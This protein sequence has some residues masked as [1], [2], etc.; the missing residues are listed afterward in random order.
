MLT[1]VGAAP[2]DVEGMTINGKV[3]LVLKGGE[4]V[5]GK[6]KVFSFALAATSR[7]PLL[8]CAIIRL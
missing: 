7:R 2:K 3:G 5:A 6:T 4:L 8:S 1:A